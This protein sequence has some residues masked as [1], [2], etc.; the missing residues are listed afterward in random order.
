MTAWN[1]IY[2][3]NT[4]RLVTPSLYGSWTCWRCGHKHVGSKPNQSG[5][6]GDCRSVT[7]TTEKK[8]LTRAIPSGVEGLEQPCQAWMRAFDDLDHPITPEGTLVAPGRRLCGHSDCV[9]PS[10]V[11][12]PDE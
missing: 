11:E 1:P 6:C 2:A 12:S 8:P 3:T 5:L 4:F 7:S 10:H 9:E